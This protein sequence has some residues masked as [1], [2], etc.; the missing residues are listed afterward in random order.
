MKAPL[1]A[2]ALAFTAQANAANDVIGGM[3][4]HT[5]TNEGTSSAYTAC[6]FRVKEEFLPER[7]KSKKIRTRSGGTYTKWLVIKEGERFYVE[8][9]VDRDGL[10]W[11][12]RAP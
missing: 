3:R 2:L 7:L 9:A 10:L 12:H 5:I 4:V 6:K 1:L 8:C 11:L